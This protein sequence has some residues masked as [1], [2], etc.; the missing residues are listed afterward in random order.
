MREVVGGVK[1]SIIIQNGVVEV[2]RDL[3]QSIFEIST[4]EK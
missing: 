2:L 4:M 3:A 1:R